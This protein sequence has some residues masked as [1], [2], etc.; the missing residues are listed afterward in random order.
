MKIVKT[1]YEG[2]ADE[3][4]A[5]EKARKSSECTVDMKLDISDIEN[6]ITDNVCNEISKAFNN[7]IGTTEEK[8]KNKVDA[9][10]DKILYLCRAQHVTVSEFES[11]LMKLEKAVNKRKIEITS[12]VMIPDCTP[13]SDYYHSF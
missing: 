4:A 1:V 12:D 8:P 3:L 9:L 2:T 11:L 13:L 6:K 5:Y 7:S 10:R